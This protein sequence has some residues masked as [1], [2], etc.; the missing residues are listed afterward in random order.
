MGD[1]VDELVHILRVRSFHPEDGLGRGRRA[2][3][4]AMPD[5]VLPFRGPRPPE[6]QQ[7]LEPCY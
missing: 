5:R 4:A 6:L 1:G 3:D 7:G 2:L